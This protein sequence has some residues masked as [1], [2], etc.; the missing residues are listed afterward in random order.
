MRKIFTLI[1]ALLLLSNSIV[2]GAIYVD[3]AIIASD[4]K[5][6]M[7]ISVPD[8]YDG[9]QKYPLVV[10]IQPCNGLP[11]KS[12]LEA[13]K[14]LTDSLQ[15]IVACPDNSATGGWIADA[16]LDVI[17]VTI[18]SVMAIYSIDEKLVYLTGMSCNGEVALRQGL[19]K[20]YPFKG[21]F[22]WDPYLTSVNP[23]IMDLNSDMPVTLAVGAN[24]DYIAATLNFYD[25]LKTH[26][27][28]VNLV[29]VPGI[30][31]T[32]NFSGFGNEM[33]RSLYYI[34]DTNNITITQSNGSAETFEMFNTDGEKEVEY[35]VSHIENKEVTVNS[36][37]S[38]TSVIGTPEIIYTPEDSIVKLKFKPIG[39]KATGRVIIVLEAREKDGTAIEQVTLK[40]KVTRKP[41]SISNLN[42]KTDVF[43][44]P[45][46][47]KLYI[48]SNEQ[49]LFV[50]ISDINGRIVL[51]AKNANAS[52]LDISSLNN[53]TYF[54]NI[55]GEKYFSNTILSVIK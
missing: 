11:Y 1:I 13:L 6:K 55:I 24:D 51:K 3:T 34:L 25:S 38:N 50:Q 8:D 7:T 5:H 33:I 54:I 23:K 17:T 26:G 52:P 37:S 32:Y 27:A 28:K 10:A 48:N 22:P 18:D 30:N 49:N 45:A 40:V 41:T 44:N 19:K 9:L 53:G 2:Q 12:Y 46:S 4:G 39:G 35:K 29:I 15:M 16:N 36:V 47:D 14:P 43:P 31:H 42:A 20:L 21:I